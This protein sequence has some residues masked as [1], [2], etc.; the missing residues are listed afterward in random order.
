M[1][2]N[3]PAPYRLPVYESLA[4]DPRIEFKF[5][6][7]SRREP[8]REWDLSAGRFEQLFLRERF[9]RFHDRFIHINPD[10]LGALKE[11]SPQ[12]VITT[13]FNPTHLL[14]YAYARMHGARHVAM[15]DGTFESEKKL[16]V[17]HRWVRRRV[18]AGSQ[19]FIGASD[20]SFDL[21]RAYG[22]DEALLFRS[23]LCA[24]NAVFFAAP[25]VEKRFDFI[26]CGRFAEVKNPL[27]VLEVAQ[28]VA[29]RLRRRIS[30]AFVGSGEMEGKMRAAATA[31]ADE[32][33]A[34][35]PGFVRQE[36]LPQFYGSARL[37]LFPTRWDPWGV[38]ANEACAAGLPILISGAAGSAREL[39]RDAENGFVLP[40]DLN[41]WV[42][43]AVK[44]LTDNDLYGKFS[45]RSRELVR[46]Y[47]YENAALGIKHAAL[48]VIAQ[49]RRPRVVVVQRMLTHYRVPL[50]ER[51]R[52]QLRE[53]DIDLAI[54]HGRGTPAEESK[55]DA[56]HLDWATQINTRYFL[57]G[58]ICWQ[59][60]GSHIANADLIIVPQENKLVYNY[61]LLLRRSPWKLAF[62]GHGR[63]MQSAKPEGI[64]ERVKRWSSRQVDWWFTYTELSARFVRNA[65]VPPDR[66]TV[67]NNAIDVEQMV[68]WREAV[69]PA[70]TNAKRQELGLTDGPIGIFVGSLY[71]EKRLE[72]LLDS[73]CEIRN[74]IDNFQL[75][76]IGDGP[77]RGRLLAAAREHNWIHWLGAKRDEEKVLLLSMAKL[78]LNPG[79]LGLGILDSFVCRVPIFTTDC[80]L[81]SP[82]IAYLENGKNGILTTNE[83]SE[84]VDAVC[85]VLRDEKQLE[86]LRDGCA[87]SSTK[88]T[89]EYMARRFCDGI[90]VCLQMPRFRS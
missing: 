45:Q 63:N 86:M 13:G 88:Y 82:E 38:V 37:F 17:L 10:V 7:C 89:I 55:R 27:F 78:M 54:V 19:S 9:I 87:E 34:V 64:L 18:Y 73:A 2:T 28:Q 43:A 40:L 46:K 77:E 14:A 35:F 32:V 20:G 84:Y 1:V 61:W 79:L 52:R 21:Y 25:P 72:F 69:T 47:S 6:F 62:W 71:A 3:I 53:Q 74:Q 58:R 60:F 49:V 36:E 26:F 16:S 11:F 4:A 50:F 75:V 76:A 56:G 66:I 59:P 67:L 44:L 81:H 90:D 23:H 68:S 33:E 42:D 31:I 15:T 29:K 39:V 57:N 8:N 12:V 24:N 30:V 41:P 65:G 83:L 5:F 22:I 48:A 80:G 51:M 85:A 70:R